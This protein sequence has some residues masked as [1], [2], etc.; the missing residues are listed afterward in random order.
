MIQLE[1]MKPF[2]ENIIS[3]NATLYENGF[4][5]VCHSQGGL[6]C[7]CLAQ[8][9]T[10]HKIRNLISLAGPQMGVYGKE[11]ITDNVPFTK[12]LP[13]LDDLIENHIYEIFDSKAFDKYLSVADMWHDPYHEDD[14]LKR[15]H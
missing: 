12:H 15:N 8:Y 11:F 1:R 6:L 14:F 4:N 10:G 3:K 7:R 2:V 5:L 13:R 9:W